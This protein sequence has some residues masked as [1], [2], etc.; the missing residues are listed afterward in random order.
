MYTGFC[1]IENTK[2]DVQKKTHKYICGKYISR[3]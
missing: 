1:Y 3:T 2:N